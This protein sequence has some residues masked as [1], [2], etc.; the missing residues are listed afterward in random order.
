MTLFASH[1]QSRHAAH[2]PPSAQNTPTLLSLQSSG[3]DVGALLV[4][5]RVGGAVL[6]VGAGEGGGEGGRV[7]GAGVGEDDGRARLEGVAL[8]G[9]D[10]ARDF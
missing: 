2:R 4:G 8:G 1:S 7:T 10:G 3:V 9:A 5:G 6:K